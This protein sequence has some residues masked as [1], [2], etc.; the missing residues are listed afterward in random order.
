MC[1]EFFFIG[2][3]GFEVQGFTGLGL[4]G[5]RGLGFRSRSCLVHN[6]R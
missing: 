6:V 1:L 4:L 2:F 3:R 5:F